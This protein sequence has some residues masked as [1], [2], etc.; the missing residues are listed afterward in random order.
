MLSFQLS[1]VSYQLLTA[2]YQPS[3]KQR[4]SD[5]QRLAA[6]RCLRPADS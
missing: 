5:A 4:I 1:A 3:Q 6:A 2:F